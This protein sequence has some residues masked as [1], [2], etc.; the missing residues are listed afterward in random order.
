MTLF[1]L[2]SLFCIIITQIHSF[3][4]GFLTKLLVMSSLYRVFSIISNHYDVEPKYFLKPHTNCSIDPKDA[5][6]HHKHHMTQQSCLVR[7]IV[8]NLNSAKL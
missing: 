3:I 7:S 6:Q 8:A 2:Y 1:K 5:A 4:Q